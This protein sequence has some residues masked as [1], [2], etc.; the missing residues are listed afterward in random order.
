MR[1]KSPTT[2]RM[3]GR[4]VLYRFCSRKQQQT[5]PGQTEKINQKTTKTQNPKQNFFFVFIVVVPVF[6]FVFCWFFPVGVFFLCWSWSFNASLWTSPSSEKVG[7]GW[8]LQPT[9]PLTCRR[10]NRCAFAKIHPTGFCGGCGPTGVLPSIGRGSCSFMEYP[11]A[12]PLGMRQTLL[13]HLVF[14]PW[15]WHLTNVW[16]DVRHASLKRLL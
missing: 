4:R 8:H 15:F 6:F 10:W 1:I 2:Q 13:Q 5:K 11:R 12:L 9:W 7:C 16:S 3:Q 14:Q